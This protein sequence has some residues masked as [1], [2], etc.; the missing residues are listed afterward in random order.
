MKRPNDGLICS[1]FSP[2][3]TFNLHNF[4]AN[5]DFL[6]VAKHE[7]LCLLKVSTHLNAVKRQATELNENSDF[8]EQGEGVIVGISG[9]IQ[10]FCF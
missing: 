1:N 10:Q 7:M 2:F 5:Y 6:H 4:Y 3:T 8:V 9:F